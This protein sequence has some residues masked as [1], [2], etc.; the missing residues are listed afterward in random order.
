MGIVLFILLVAV[1]LYAP[2]LRAMLPGANGNTSKGVNGTG[3]N[4]T[5][6]TA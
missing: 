4:R 6:A 2:K 3:A 5:L 1:I